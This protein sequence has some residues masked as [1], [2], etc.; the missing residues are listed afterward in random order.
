MGHIG[1]RVQLTYS[2]PMVIPRT[3]RATTLNI[4]PLTP[5]I[6]AELNG[7]DLATVDDTQ[8]HEIHAAL[9]QHLVVFFR[10]QDISPSQQAEFARR[11]GRTRTAQKASFE[12]RD[13]V[14]EMSVL[15]ND[16][17]RP[18]NVNHYHADGIFRRSPEFGAM[19]YAVEVPPVGGDTIFVNMQAAYDGLSDELRH[20]VDNKLASNDFMKLHG[21]P[22]KARSWR[23]D[24]AAGMEA[25]RRENPPVEHPMVR[26]HPVTGKRSLWLSES[27]TTHIVGV[28]STESHGML[29]TLFRH[30]SKPEYQCRFKWRKGSMAFWDNRGTMHYAVADYW[31]HRRLMHRITI[32]TDRI[33]APEVEGLGELKP[34]NMGNQ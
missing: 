28:S 34:M 13:D 9:M 23:G 14:P 7:V 8:L 12:I 19:L 16:E 30:C 21:S 1:S 31:P 4:E 25:A 6:G 27:F 2:H 10:D 22:A 20:Y 29:D 11:F 3:T 17:E 18:P 24:N 32:E 26:V 5:L 33:G 15:I